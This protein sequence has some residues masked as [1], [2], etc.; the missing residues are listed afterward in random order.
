[1]LRISQHT[2]TLI[3]DGRSRWLFLRLDYI[4]LAG[5]LD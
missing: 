1:M 2:D 5:P 4:L 3:H